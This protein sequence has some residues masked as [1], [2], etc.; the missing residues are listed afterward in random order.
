MQAI[1]NR[2]AWDSEGE[3]LVREMVNRFSRKVVAVQEDT[4][5]F[6]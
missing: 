4:I 1:K 6:T 2:D 5:H 3:E